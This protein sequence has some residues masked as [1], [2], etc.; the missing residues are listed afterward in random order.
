MLSNTQLLYFYI[1]KNLHYNNLHI[2]CS[3]LHEKVHLCS[4]SAYMH[5]FNRFQVYTIFI[6][7]FKK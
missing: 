2:I 3:N 4:F 6:P 1:G 5:I 7:Q